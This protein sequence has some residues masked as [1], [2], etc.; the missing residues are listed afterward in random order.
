MTDRSATATVA[1]VDRS[2]ALDRLLRDSS[3]DLLGTVI[4][5]LSAKDACHASGV[6]R[7][8]ARVAEP[9]LRS[10]CTAQGWQLAR[11]PRL[12]A[13]STS[14]ATEL[15]WRAVFV[16]RSCRHCMAAPGDYA[17]RGYAGGAPKLFLCGH[18]ARESVVVA[19]LQRL[20]ATIDVTGLSG[21]PLY[22]KKQNKFCAEV[23]KESK[24]SLD[25]APGQRADLLR[26]GR[27]HAA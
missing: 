22:T 24:L 13:R 26:R 7:R 5:C 4:G 19:H 15:P 23:S 9:H 11:R 18:C 20:R 21:K 12:L 10:V 17:V 1:A 8:W 3:D 16:A 25:N 2:G 14:L 6:C 27:S